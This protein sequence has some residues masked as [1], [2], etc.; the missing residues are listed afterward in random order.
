[1]SFLDIINENV[2]KPQ[3]EWVWIRMKDAFFTRVFRERHENV[4][5][6]WF[7]EK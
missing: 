6:Y 3:E 5:H 4:I 2:A 7:E 1:V